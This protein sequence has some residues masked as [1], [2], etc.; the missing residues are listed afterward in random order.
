M[1]IFIHENF[2]ILG[3]WRTLLPFM[4]N[5]L[6]GNFTTYYFTIVFILLNCIYTLNG[7]GVVALV[8]LIF[9]TI[10]CYIRGFVMYN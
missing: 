4:L 5:A 8:G 6:V 2:P 9:A 7:Y 1:N 10:I 3:N